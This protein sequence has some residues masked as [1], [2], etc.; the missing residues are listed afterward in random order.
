VNEEEIVADASAILAALKSQ[1]FSNLDPRRLVG[2][3]V[4]AVN[5]CEVLSKLHD[6]GLNDTQAEAAVSNMDLNV[7]AFDTSQAR[8]AARLRSTT[9]YAGLSLGDRA[10]LALG[11]HLG[12]PVITADRAW[13]SLNIGVEV[14]VIR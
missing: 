12:H 11:L 4:S 2:A 1:P 6:D 5:V 14:V 10:C 9:R 8:I 3:T 13:A 7:V